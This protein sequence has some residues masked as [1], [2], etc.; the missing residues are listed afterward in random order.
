MKKL[1]TLLA[2]I[3]LANVLKAQ[4][5]DGTAVFNR[6]EQPAVI[7]EFNYSPAVVEAVLMDDM[8]SRGFGKGSVTKGYHK[9][10]GIMFPYLS[11]DKIDFY[12]KVSEKNK[13][14]GKSMVSALV[15]K[16]GEMF[17]SS[18]YD[19]A[20]MDSTKAYLM[21]FTEAF[22]QKKLDFDIEDQRQVLAK[23]E[24]KYENLVGDG[25]SM[26]TKLKNLESDIEKNKQEQAKQ[27]DLLDKEKQLLET[28]K[29]QKK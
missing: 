3:G 1:F 18:A 11:S 13:E 19:P 17:V 29:S 25:E 12:F 21:G 23:A 7:A 24:K 16:G 8:K 15:S 27:K 6:V 9:F 22:D 14:K 2:V 20:I 26:V 28:L 10:E 5:A 4:V